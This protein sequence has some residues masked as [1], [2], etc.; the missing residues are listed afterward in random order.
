MLTPGALAIAG[1]I[2]YQA[3]MTRRNSKILILML[4][5]TFSNAGHAVDR[6]GLLKILGFSAGGLFTPKAMTTAVVAFP[7]EAATAV[8]PASPVAAASSAMRASQIYDLYRR[9]AYLDGAQPA[10]DG[11]DWVVRDRLKAKFSDTTRESIKDYIAASREMLALLEVQP[12]AYENRP[13]IKYQTIEAVYDFPADRRCVKTETV[14]SLREVESTLAKRF[15]IDETTVSLRVQAILY[16]DW[17]AR[18]GLAGNLREISDQLDLSHDF[19]DA[20]FS[21]LVDLLPDTAVAI[22]RRYHKY[23]KSGPQLPVEDL[24]EHLNIDYSAVSRIR[25]GTGRSYPDATQD[26][27][28]YEFTDMPWVKFDLERIE[29]D[30]EWD[31]NKLVTYPPEV[32]VERYLGVLDRLD[33]ITADLSLV[34]PSDL[35]NATM[36]N[37]TD[38][39]TT[40]AREFNEFP[41]RHLNMVRAYEVH[42]KRQVVF[43]LRNK[44][45]SAAASSNLTEATGGVDFA[46]RWTIALDVALRAAGQLASPEPLHQAQSDLAIVNGCGSALTSVE[47]QLE[48]KPV[49]DLID[50]QNVQADPVESKRENSGLR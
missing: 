10:L 33:Q 44:R 50:P 5:L 25:I 18:A 47:A 7:V 12:W 39:K 34:P 30:S 14:R 38:L 46:R 17:L 26:L 13:K 49:A 4:G 31:R 3:A 37:I 22:A 36:V 32:L 15:G 24:Q 11:D 28:T 42:L 40:L 48:F 1:G 43:G 23:L 29:T 19:V 27:F 41:R 9:R 8:A 16:P 35:L 6:R 2:A 45:K 21:L 20:Y